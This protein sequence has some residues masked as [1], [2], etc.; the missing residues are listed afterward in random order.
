MRLFGNHRSQM[1]SKCGKNRKEAHEPL[2]KC[3]T[4][5]NIIAIII[6]IEI[7]IIIIIIAIIIII[8]IIELLQ[9]TDQISS[10]KI[11]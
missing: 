11:Q 6:I 8:I 9:R 3:V 4:N 2:G 7:I 1:M 5:L 10:L